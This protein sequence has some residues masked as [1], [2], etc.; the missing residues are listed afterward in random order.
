M[1][2]ERQF[3]RIPGIGEKLAEQIHRE[4]KIESLEELEM[5]ANDGRL[6]SLDG[7][8]SKR[9]LAVKNALESL[10]R[11]RRFQAHAASDPEPA[12]ETLL[13]VDRLYRERENANKL[14]M[15]APKRFNPEQNA[16]LPIMHLEL[17]EW[18]FTAL[19][20]NTA[21]AHKLGKTHDWVVL[22]FE[23]VDDHHHGQASV[24]TE[25]RGKLKRKRVVRGREEQCLECYRRGVVDA[26][27]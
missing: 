25:Y 18:I 9:V 16:W 27:T 23:N 3:G 21:R 7:L 24:V 10:F 15:I 6:G 14:K 19:F 22:F 11:R 20:S 4:L 17:D 2:A 8:G 12:V 5:A 1:S 13:E 26:A